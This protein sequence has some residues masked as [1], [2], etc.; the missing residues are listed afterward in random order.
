MSSKVMSCKDS[1]EKTKKHLRSVLISEKGG[2]ALDRLEMDYRELVGQSLPYQALGFHSTTA[3]LEAIPDVCSLQRR[4]GTL[5]VVGLASSGT[6]HILNMV[7]RQ[8][9]KQQGRGGGVKSLRGGG[10]RAAGQFDGRSGQQ[11]GGSNSQHNGCDGRAQGQGCMGSTEG[12]KTSYGNPQQ[13]GPGGRGK[14]VRGN[15]PSGNL[16]G[17]S[18]NNSPGSRFPEKFPGNGSSGNQP[19]GKRPPCNKLSGNNF[20]GTLFPGNKFSGTGPSGSGSFGNWPPGNGPPGNRLHGNELPSSIQDGKREALQLCKGRVGNNEQRGAV[21]KS[22][23]SDTGRE[24]P[25]FVFGGNLS[26]VPS[27]SESRTPVKTPANQAQPA[28]LKKIPDLAKALQTAVKETVSDSVLHT[29]TNFKVGPNAMMSNSETSPRTGSGG[30]DQEERMKQLEQRVG[31][32]EQQLGEEKAAKETLLASVE[33]AL[34]GEGV[35]ATCSEFKLVRLI[36]DFKTK[37]QRHEQGEKAVYLDLN[38]NET[39]AEGNA[40]AKHCKSGSPNKARI[41]HADMGIK[42]RPGEAS[43]TAKQN[44]VAFLPRALALNMGNKGDLRSVRRQKQE[45]PGVRGNLSTT[46]SMEDKMVEDKLEEDKLMEDKL[47]SKSAKS[48]S[49][50]PRSP[51]G[52]MLA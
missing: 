7:N 43:N 3:L 34:A 21:L 8:G 47:L 51:D 1:I 40:A 52:R 41:L 23:K 4:N 28:H 37:I 42:A 20:P 30:Q 26:T 5:M 44:P 22:S 14:L 27:T 9:K 38:G 19:P 18:G 35:E 36:Q 13:S 31:D 39:P 25:T 10:G 29:T 32:L 33:R 17:S 45:G 2:V 48:L 11:N 50:H 16:N 46:V 49:C 15:N 24:K 6:A 12:V